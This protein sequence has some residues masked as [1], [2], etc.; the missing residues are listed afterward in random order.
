MGEIVK[1]INALTG[2]GFVVV[3][4]IA[5]WGWFFKRGRRR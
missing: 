3:L 2:L 4:G 1:L 5:A